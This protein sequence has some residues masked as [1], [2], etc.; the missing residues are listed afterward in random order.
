MQTRRKSQCPRKQCFILS[1][2]ESK[3]PRCLKAKAD[4]VGQGVLLEE[5]SNCNDTF[6]TTRKIP[7]LPRRR[8][9]R[10]R[11]NC[12]DREFLTVLYMLISAHSLGKG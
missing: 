11:E 2:L 3:Q 9:Q 4:R 8:N 12:D 1:V 10:E 7:L 5:Q 6:I